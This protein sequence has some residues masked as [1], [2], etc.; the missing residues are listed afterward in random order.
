MKFG[1]VNIASA[2]IASLMKKINKV[3]LNPLIGFLFA[4]ALAYFLYGVV[5]FII[6]RDNEEKRSQGKEHMI[7][8]VVGMFIMM[9]AFGIINLIQSTLGA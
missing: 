8:G 3:I 1:L 5:E 4:L 6:N 7:W 9:A 2:D